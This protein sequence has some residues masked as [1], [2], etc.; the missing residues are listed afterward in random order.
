M[1]NKLK[2]SLGLVFLSLFWNACTVQKCVY[3]KGFN[4]D[5]KGFH[6]T[7]KS[8]EPAA[9]QAQFSSE[10]ENEAAAEENEVME[11]KANQATPQIL[12]QNQVDS[13]D[14]VEKGL[15]AIKS[16]TNPGEVKSR[17]ASR[18]SK[19]MAQTN[20]L[21]SANAAPLAPDWLILL[22]CIFIPPIA[23]ALMSN[24]NIQKILI[25]LLLWILGVLPGVV[26]AFL[27]FLHY[28]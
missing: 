19:S 13:F 11:A 28:L 12:A 14:K 15:A 9:K 23:V 5:F 27:V 22:L 2:W 8:N 6:G 26:Y 7:K 3:S 20:V 18:V 1:K 16:V 24:G 21:S 4:V 10:I 25:A 17:I